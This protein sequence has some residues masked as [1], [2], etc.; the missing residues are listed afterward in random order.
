MKKYRSLIP[1]VLVI[2]MAVSCY[3]MISN[4]SKNESEYNNYLSEARKW[5]N[6][7][8]TKYAIENYNAA[9]KIKDTPEVRVEVSEMYK[10]LGKDKENLAWCKEF[11]EKYPTDYRSY[12]CLLE[13]Y[14]KDKD[15][16]SCYDVLETATKRNI[17]SDYIKDISSQ[18]EYAFSI[19]FN[20][21]SDV[22][23]YSNNFCA[24]KSN[25]LWGFVDRYG[26]KRVSGNYVEV[27]AYTQS[28]FASVVNNKGDTYFIDKTGAKVITVADKYESFGVL[29]G[30]VFAAKKSD[31]KYV[32]LA[33]NKS[34]DDSSLYKVVSE[35]FEYA[36]TFNNGVAAVKKSGKWQIINS[37]F[38]VI[39]EGYLDVIV[40]E[41][42]IAF[43]ND[44][45]FVSKE[46][47]KYIMIDKNGKQI[48]KLS[49]ENARVFA[50]EG[51]TA[52]CIEGKWSFIN[53]DG[54]LISDKKYEDARAFS[55]GLAAVCLNEKWGFV[56][57]SE[58]IV[59]EPQF[60]GAKDFNE[61]GS[62][63]VKTGD[64][65]QL[66]KLYRLNREG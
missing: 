39:T 51:A 54:N 66:L 11:F 55:S 62:C 38:K 15:Y 27:G 46:D 28:G 18:I 21:Y 44:R 7:D 13:S 60:F 4:A 45:L 64:K 61:K 26:N 56:N 59:I 17:K 34:S 40:D 33:E 20:S 30:G 36:S 22:G 3:M 35:E 25:E 65:W 47:G 29:V 41:K 43:R 2:L 31:G 12:D 32:Y 63:F 57:E 52:V 50:G 42:Q 58:S 53:K 1:V 9:L 5:S 19:D 48:G 16:K 23:I 6:Q 14:Y 10:R 37:D 24:V 8:I 49:F